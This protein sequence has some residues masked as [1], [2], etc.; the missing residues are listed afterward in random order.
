MIGAALGDAERGRVAGAGA[1]VWSDSSSST[2][3]SIPMRS[4]CADEGL[5]SPRVV[6]ARPTGH[7]PAP[8]PGWAEHALLFEARERPPQ[9]HPAHVELHAE[10]ALGGQALADPERA[11]IDVA[12]DP[13]GD[14]HPLRI[15]IIERRDGRSI[16]RQ[17]V[18][19]RVGGFS[20]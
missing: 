17:R 1:A 8:A 2:V 11:A 7:E 6:Q 13:I 9:G 3:V 18:P 14:P 12:H 5:Q 20:S 16:T 10:V 4:R 15:G 19:H